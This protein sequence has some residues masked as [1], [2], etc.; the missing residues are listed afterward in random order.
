MK[1]HF[2]DGNKVIINRETPD[3]KVEEQ[4]FQVSDV[5][6]LDVII[7]TGEGKAKESEYRTTVFKRALER[8]YQLKTKHGRAFMAEV[9]EKYPALCFS[10]RLFEDEIT[11]KLAVQEC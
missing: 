9:I 5:F 8:Q 11:A 1:K 2:I 3:Q 6:A 7:S 10:L 4:E